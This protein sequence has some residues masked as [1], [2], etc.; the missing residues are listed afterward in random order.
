MQ[1][2]Y[3]EYR[4]SILSEKDLEERINMLDHIIRDSGAYVRDQERWPEGS[5]TNDT[6]VVMN[7]AKKRMEYLDEA[8]FD[9]EN[10]IK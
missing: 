2:L 6:A 1:K 4:R 10:Y 9:L 7:F 8:L 3:N 5:Y